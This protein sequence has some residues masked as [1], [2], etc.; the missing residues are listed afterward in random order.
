MTA[1]CDHDGHRVTEVLALLHAVAGEHDLLAILL[2][3]SDDGPQVPQLKIHLKVL[4]GVSL[5]TFTA[6][7]TQIIS[8]G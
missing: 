5:M 1:E 8:L 4:G 6:A 2:D 3:R 7:I